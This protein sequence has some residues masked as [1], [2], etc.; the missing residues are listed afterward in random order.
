MPHYF[1]ALE[2]RNAAELLR[3]YLDYDLLSDATDLT[4]DYIDA[5]LGKG[6]EYFGLQ[7]HATATAKAIIIIIII[8]FI[9][10]HIQIFLF[11]ALH[12]S[13]LTTCCRRTP[14]AGRHQSGCP[15]PVLVDAV[16]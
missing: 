7:V 3:L 12:L 1:L 9:E 14:T 6:K 5:V 16:L 13:P 11:V 2:V 10:R 8:L 15:S 4:M